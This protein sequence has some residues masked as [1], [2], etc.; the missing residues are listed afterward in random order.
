MADPNSQQLLDATEAA[1]GDFEIIFGALPPASIVVP[2]ETID[3]VTQSRL[4]DNGYVTIMPWI[5]QDVQ[6]EL[7]NQ[8][9]IKQI[10]EQLQGR[11]QALIDAAIASARSQL[12]PQTVTKEE[13]QDL[14]A[15]SHELGHKWFIDRY[16]N[17]D[18]A[19]T[20]HAYG[21]W[22]PDWLDESAAIAME[23]ENGKQRR[24]MRFSNL[25]PEAR[26][27][28]PEFLTMVHP[29]AQAGRDLAEGLRE[30]RLPPME[31]GEVNRTFIRRDMSELPDAAQLSGNT[32]SA[33]TSQVIRLTGEEAQAFL[34][35]SGGER[36]P[37]FYAQAI[38]FSDYLESRSGEPKI[39]SVIASALSAGDNFTTWLSTNNQGLPESVEALDEDWTEYANG[40]VATAAAD[41]D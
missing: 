21:G 13:S 41:A 19:Q 10:K 23:S 11:P 12:Q 26:I 27:P 2:T 17:G 22:A 31:G 33:R 8:D 3:A 14:S 16:P 4:T 39:L 38:V 15:L 6:N 25:E 35:K 9:V 36:A 24:R 20:S 40:Y 1:A 28:L 34:A 37:N 7:R 30:T 18:T 29:A 32:T 5:S